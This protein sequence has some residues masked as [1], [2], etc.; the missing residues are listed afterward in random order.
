M[1]DTTDH[2][3]NAALFGRIGFRSCRLVHWIPPSD[4]QPHPPLRSWHAN[5][6]IFTFIQ[7]GLV[8]HAGDRASE[9]Q[10]PSCID[11]NVSRVLWSTA[12]L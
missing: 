7:Q 11:R 6:P 4:D 8:V 12:V 10:S 2:I 3:H 5:C 1:I 9:G